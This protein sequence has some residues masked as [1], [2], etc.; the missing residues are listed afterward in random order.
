MPIIWEYLQ[1][2][3]LGYFKLFPCNTDT[4]F[5]TCISIALESMLIY[6][7]GQ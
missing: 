1:L 3:D 5:A 6:T 2:R 7:Y 4:A